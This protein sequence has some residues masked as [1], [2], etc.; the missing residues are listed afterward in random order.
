MAQKHVYG[1][2]Q[3]LFASTSDISINILGTWYSSKS[4]MA[5][6][7]LL[8]AAEARRAGFPVLLIYEDLNDSIYQIQVI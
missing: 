4:P 6:S 3:G 8:V 2:V 1:L 7:I 5:T